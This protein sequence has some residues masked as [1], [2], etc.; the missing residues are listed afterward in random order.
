VLRETGLTKRPDFRSSLRI[1]GPRFPEDYAS[2]FKLQHCQPLTNT[3]T[4]QGNL[5]DADIVRHFG[6]EYFVDNEDR[7]MTEIMRNREFNLG[8]P[9]TLYKFRIPFT[10]G[11][12]SFPSSAG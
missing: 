12:K 8:N 9:T 1:A 7:G 11:V 2:Q 4:C 3:H 10:R 5:L 6:L